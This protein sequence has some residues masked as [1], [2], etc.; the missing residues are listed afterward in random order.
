MSAD[1]VST[2]GR[3]RLTIEIDWPNSFDEKATAIDINKTVTRECESLLR[4]AL[5]NR[6]VQYRII[7]EIEP[8]MV[9][10]PTKR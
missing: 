10:Y 9:I 4:R 7:G 6:G 5:D 2:S 3:I 8:I 1:K